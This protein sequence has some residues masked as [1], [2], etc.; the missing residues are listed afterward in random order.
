MSRTDYNRQ[1]RCKEIIDYL[2]IKP[3]ATDEEL[4]KHFKVSINTI[5]LDRGRL[6]IKEVKERLKQKAL[7]NM[8]HVTTISKNEFVGNM[9]EYKPGK[10]ALS[11][12]NTSKE[13]TF[14]GINV[15]KGSIIYS[16]AESIALSL[17]PTKA[18]LVGVASI[19]YVNKVYENE[20]IYASA[21]VKRKTSTGYIV[22][23]KILNKDDIQVF[24]GKF[25]LKGIS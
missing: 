2:E 19:K 22:W 12:L 11:I 1:Q 23:V 3:Y 4:A 10:S 6:K 20:T 17:I 18:A 14:K 21:E 16:F 9:L 25:I 7:E 5:R 8:K 15:V 13:M 24:R